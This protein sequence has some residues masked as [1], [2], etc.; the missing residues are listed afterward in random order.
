MSGMLGYGVVGV[1]ILPAR[2]RLDLYGLMKI[3]REEMI[4]SAL[5]EDTIQRE[6]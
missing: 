5:R 1:V 6:L 2:I 4:Q 3:V